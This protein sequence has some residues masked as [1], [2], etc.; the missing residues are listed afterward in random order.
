MNSLHDKENAAVPRPK[1]YKVSKAPF[2]HKRVPLGGKDQNKQ[3]SLY[4]AKLVVQPALLR[5]QTQVRPPLLRKSLSEAP[6]LKKANSSLGIPLLVRTPSVLRRETNPL[7]NS[8]LNNTL[9]TQHTTD[10]LIKKSAPALPPVASLK[11]T[12]SR[13]TRLR[14]R[15]GPRSHNT[16]PVKRTF[17]IPQHLIDDPSS[18]ETIPERS[19]A[20]DAMEVFSDSELGLSVPEEQLKQ[21]LDDFDIESDDLAPALPQGL[22]QHELNDLLDF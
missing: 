13:H 7:K 17:H 1:D 3:P 9:P 6:S 2:R 20:E 8:L 22:S 16:D 14:P 19:V 4:K 15:D 12:F 5:S 11:S 18:I 10:L 21:K